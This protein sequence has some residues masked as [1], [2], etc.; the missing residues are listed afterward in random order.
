M[1]LF[2]D[3]LVEAYTLETEE[4]SAATLRSSSNACIED[5]YIIVNRN[6]LFPSHD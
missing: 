5:R 4:E 2:V 3:L 6:H 1:H